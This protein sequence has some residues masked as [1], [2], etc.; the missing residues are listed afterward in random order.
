MSFGATAGGRAP[1]VLQPL[2][3]LAGNARRLLAFLGPATLISVGYIDPG[4]WATD[5]EGGARF[6]YGLLWVLVGSSVMA[7]LLQSLSARLGIV[8]GLNLAQ[9]C[10]AAYSRRVARGL[11]ILAEIGIVA[12]DAAEVMG[13]AI[14]LNMLFGLPLLLGAVLTTLDVLVIL[15]LQDRRIAVLEMCIAALLGVI[16]VCLTPR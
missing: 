1:H 11:W 13:S 4:N 3:F 5:L 14:A 16:G 8:S 6:G 2:R 12:C 7:V 15:V 9:A 10:R